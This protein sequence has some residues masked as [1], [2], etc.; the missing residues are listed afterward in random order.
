MDTLYLW[1]YSHPR[2]GRVVTRS[3]RKSATCIAGMRSAYFLVA[4]PIRCQCRRMTGRKDA[5]GLGS[6]PVDVLDVKDVFVEH[7]ATE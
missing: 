3:S 4:G 2:D 6:C 5:K 1:R 7:R